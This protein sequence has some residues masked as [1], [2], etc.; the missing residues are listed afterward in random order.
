MGYPW[1]IAGPS[2]EIQGLPRGESWGAY[3][4]SVR[5]LQTAHG[6]AMGYAWATLTG[7]PCGNHRL[8]MGELWGTHGSLAITGL[9]L[10]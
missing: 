10:Q 3:V 6:L 4:A 7:Y 8:P 9:S 5:Y 2:L 1:V